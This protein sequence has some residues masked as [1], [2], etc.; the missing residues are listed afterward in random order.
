[1]RNNFYLCGAVT[2]YVVQHRDYL[3]KVFSFYPYTGNLVNFK[4]HKDGTLIT[5][6]DMCN[7]ITY[8][9]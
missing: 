9:L 4:R 6:I 3:M 7:F 8:T 2:M 1:M 5:C